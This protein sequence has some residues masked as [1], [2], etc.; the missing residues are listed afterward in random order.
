VISSSSSAEETDEVVP[1][2]V[3]PDPAPRPVRRSFTAAYRLA[4]VTQYEAAPRGEKGAVL[5]REG[6]YYSY[7]GMDRSPLRRGPLRARRR[8]Q[9][10]DWVE[11][12]DQGSWRGRAVACPEPPAD[13]P[14]DP[15]SD[16][17]GHHGK[18]ARALGDALREHGHPGPAEEVMSVAFDGLREAGVATRT[19]CSLTGRPRASRS[20]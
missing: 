11:G 7:Q 20:P 4:I 19:A 14:A 9:I 1:E 16:G 12:V 6:L 13:R 3:V 18:S 10:G 17:V 8:T 2:A 5:R 15:D